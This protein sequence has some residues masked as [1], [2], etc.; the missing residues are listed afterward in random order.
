MLEEA[1]WNQ[2]LSVAGV[3]EAGRGALAG[4]VV[5]AAVVLSPGRHPYRDSKKLSTRQREIMLDHVLASAISWSVAAASAAEVDRLGVLE[6]THQAAYRALSRLRRQ[7]QA[8]ITDYLFLKLDS[9]LLAPPRAED[10]SPSVAAASILAKVVRDRHMQGLDLVYPQYGFASHKGYGT[11][12][13]LA[14]LELLGP[15]PAH[16][17]SFKPVAQARLMF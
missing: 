10:A 9:P 12:E 15:C 1:F 14:A 3:D 6:A 11:S 2:G 17:R 7:P 4:P 13:H 8:V 5:V 16:R